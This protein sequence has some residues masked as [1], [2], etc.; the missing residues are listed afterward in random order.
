MT[1]VN[2]ESEAE[3]TVGATEEDILDVIENDEITSE[4]VEASKEANEAAEADQELTDLAEE[5]TETIGNIEEKLEDTAEVVPEDVAVAQESLRHYK[6]MLGIKDEG[7]K[8]SLESMR[9]D[10]KA[11]LEGIKVELEGVLDTIKDSAKKVWDWIVSIFKKIKELIIAGFNKL[12]SFFKNLAW[13]NKSEQ[14][15]VVDDIVKAMEDITKSDNT[16]INVALYKEAV[17]DFNDFEEELRAA[18]AEDLSNMVNTYA[19]IKKEGAAATAKSVDAYNMVSKRAKELAAKVKGGDDKKALLAL[20]KPKEVTKKEEVKTVVNMIEPKAAEKRIADLLEDKYCLLGLM[21]PAQTQSMYDYILT[22]LLK[23]GSETIKD[24]EAA[25]NG[26][27][28]EVDISVMT[29]ALYT[30]ITSGLYTSRG[31]SDYLMAMPFKIGYKLDS[32]YGRNIDPNDIILN[33]PRVGNTITCVLRNGEIVKTDVNLFTINKSFDISTIGFVYS[34][35][36]LEDTL[37]EVSN[38]D[39]KYKSDLDKFYASLENIKKLMDNGKLANVKASKP[40]ASEDNDDYVSQFKFSANDV[41]KFCKDMVAL[42]MML[43]ESYYELS[44][45][46]VYALGTVNKVTVNK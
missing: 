2:L 30:K 33:I 9:V 8:I 16:Y 10:T 20:P 46:L 38:F 14:L 25:L 3:E 44:S 5:V 24:L 12:V 32:V 34:A 23:Y 19:E 29:A 35:S 22:S 41:T 43:I 15:K 11:N 36:A 40:A 28:K 45:Y 42:T 17:D 21:H 27:G 13:K 39:K 37:K 31:I 18:A 26:N 1:K 7:T 4:L 6:K